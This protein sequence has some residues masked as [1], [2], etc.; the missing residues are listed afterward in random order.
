M[1]IASLTGIALQS[2]PLPEGVSAVQFPS[3]AGGVRGCRLFD[4]GGKMR[5]QQEEAQRLWWEAREKKEAEKKWK[6]RCETAK[7]LSQAVIQW[8]HVCRDRDKNPPYRGWTVPTDTLWHR[9][10]EYVL[11]ARKYIEGKANQNVFVCGAS[12]QGKSKL[13]R[14]LLALM[15]G[16]QRVVFTFKPNDEYLN[17]GFPIADVTEI[18]PNPFED[19]D[20]FTSAFAITYPLDSVGITASQVP[21]FVR[22]LATGC[23]G[24]DPFVKAVEKRIHETK[25]KIQLSAL[26][27]IEEHVKGLHYDTKTSNTSL[28]SLLS[29]LKLDTLVIDFS[30]LNDGAKVFYAELFL[31]QLWTE[32]R[33]GQREKKLVVSVDEAHRLTNGTF[34]RYHSIIHEIS[35][36]IRLSGALWVSTQNYSDLEDGIRNQFETQFVFRTT[37][38]RD[39]AALKA[40]DPMVSYTVSALPDHYFVDA[41]AVAGN[42]VWYFSYHPKVARIEGK[43]IHWVVEADAPRHYIT[44]KLSSVREVKLGAIIGMIREALKSRVFYASEMAREVSERLGVKEDD[45][46]LMVNDC[47]RRLAQAGEVRRMRFEREDGTS[48]VLHYASP[49]E[50]QAESTLHQYLVSF[51]ARLLRDRGVQ[52]V[53]VANPSEPLADIETGDALYEIETGL[54]KRTDDLEER[55]ARTRK[56][57]VIA[58]PNS[59]IAESEMYRR[60]RSDTVK[61]VTVS[62]LIEMNR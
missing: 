30:G 48:V 55:I 31:R 21:S 1:M 53:H 24:W 29:V 23:N 2:R 10:S 38:E 14:R 42:G 25:D 50:G 43:E 52:V 22:D 60:L 45:A 26:H 5:K 61:V 32:L 59:D 56:P 40:I 12:G 34:G 6:E 57:V 27:F 16:Y 37:S 11:D 20:A 28:L 58:V 46:K 33:Q 47:C 15:D 39:L 17:A 4:R 41:K 19:L 51:V 54:K 35:K 49:E 8:G 13:M 44:Q 9:P 36:E 3:K 62:G 7:M 18:M